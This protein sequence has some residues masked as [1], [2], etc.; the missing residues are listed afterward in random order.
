MSNNIAIVD[1]AVE[2]AE[3]E[4]ESVGYFERV[5]N[6]TVAVEYECLCCGKID[7]QYYEDVAEAD[8]E[9]Y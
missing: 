8:E 1:C 4:W 2:D 5:D 9:D 3:H 6:S 7:Y